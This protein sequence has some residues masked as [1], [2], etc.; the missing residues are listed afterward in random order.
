MSGVAGVTK[1]TDEQR[2]SGGGDSR[3][4]SLPSSSP[5][6]DVVLVIAMILRLLGC[7]LL[8]TGLGATEIVEAV[9]FSVSPS[10]PLASTKLFLRGTRTL[11]RLVSLF[12]AATLIALAMVRADED[13]E[14]E[15]ATLWAS[16]RSS[17]CV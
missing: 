13:L 4:G 3:E 8:L 1:D 7:C 10:M 11:S 14:N 12:F 6:W 17:S 5:W 16:K 15:R 2:D 9:R